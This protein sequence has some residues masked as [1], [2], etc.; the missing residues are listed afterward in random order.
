MQFVGWRSKYLCASILRLFC[1]C[2]RRNWAT[3][4]PRSGRF[5]RDDGRGTANRR[6]VF[7]QFVAAVA[8]RDSM[9]WPALADLTGG[10]AV[11][12]PF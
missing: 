1:S 10:A 9:L 12:A 7:R 11:S 3:T 4:S 6:R 5:D 8:E 2:V